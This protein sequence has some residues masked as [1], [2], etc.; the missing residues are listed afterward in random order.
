MPVHE[1]NVTVPAQSIKNADME[2]VIDADGRRFGRVK[3]SRG[4]IDWVPANGTVT[5]RLSWEKFA[6]LMD[7]HGQRR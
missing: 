7:E 6:Q 3:I 4:S 5:R 1:I 2:I